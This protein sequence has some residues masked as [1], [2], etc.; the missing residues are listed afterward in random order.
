MQ[1]HG[2]GARPKTVDQ[3]ERD[4]DEAAINILFGRPF[5]LGLDGGGQ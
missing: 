2:G 4:P 3:R 1:P 5:Q